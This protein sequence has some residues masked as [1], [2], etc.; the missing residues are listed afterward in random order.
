MI[1]YDLL[2]LRGRNIRCQGA[3]TSLCWG[4]G[5][6]CELFP[7]H[8]A[9]THVNTAI[10]TNLN[11]L[12]SLRLVAVLRFGHEDKGLSQTFSISYLERLAFCLGT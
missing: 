3:A 1:W 2:S 10:S 4:Q 12:E 5:A 7:K 8:V 9:A 6:P 11:Q